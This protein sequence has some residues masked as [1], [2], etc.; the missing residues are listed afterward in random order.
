MHEER[1]APTIATAA[2]YPNFRIK[3]DCF[4][5]LV[6]T[7][8]FTVR[9]VVIGKVM[10]PQASCD[11]VRGGRGVVWQTPPRH[12]TP[13]DGYCSGRYASYWNAFLLLSY[14]LSIKITNG[15]C[16]THIE[17][18]EPPSVI[19]CKVHAYT[20]THFYRIFQPNVERIWNFISE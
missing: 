18:W 11:S 7:T 2:L 13:R 12:P 15:L 6:N 5:I 14:F 17:V 8:N 1:S 19:D 10:F 3:L 20:F 16:C 9:I 4:L